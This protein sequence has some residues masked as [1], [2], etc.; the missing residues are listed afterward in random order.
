L[1]AGLRSSRRRC[2]AVAGKDKMVIITDFLDGVSMKKMLMVL[3]IVILAIV[4]Y[5][6]K[7]KKRAESGE[8]KSRSTEEQSKM[9]QNEKSDTKAY[10]S[11]IA[12]IRAQP[13]TAS[14]E[15]QSG[16]VEDFIDDT[17]KQPEPRPIVSLEDFFEGN[18][19]LGSIGCNLIDYP[20]IP[21]FYEVLKS[22]RAKDNVQD[23]LVEISEVD[24]EFLDW[25]FSE[26][27]Y[28]LTSA[29]KEEIGKWMEPLQPDE[30][31]EGW[32][33]KKAPSAAPKLQ[34]GMRVFG[35]WWD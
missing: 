19:D 15:A 4:T 21:K 23:V 6:C 1:A 22:I 9:A 32:G 8:I 7:Y 20:E 35:A 26:T 29:S 11:L 24:E 5:G 16:T 13:E 17:H 27:V 30:I 28:I 14:I 18:K 12:K 25:P 34:D 2:R 3:M 10:E 33:F 31:F